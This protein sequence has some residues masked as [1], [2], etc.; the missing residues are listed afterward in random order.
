MRVILDIDSDNHD[1]LYDDTAID[2]L[3]AG[4]SICSSSSSY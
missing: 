4:Q 2:K 3:I 1:D